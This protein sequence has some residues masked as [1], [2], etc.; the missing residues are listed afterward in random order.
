MAVAR[1][2]EYFVRKENK[3]N[4]FIFNNSSP[5]CHPIAPIWHTLDAAD[6][7]A[8]VVVLSILAEYAIWRKRIVE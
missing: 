5:P 3:N 4:D 7:H 1:I 2:R 6:E 8:S